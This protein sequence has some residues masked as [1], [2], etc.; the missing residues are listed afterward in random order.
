MKE[1]Y[2]G[3]DYGTSN[4]CVGIYM[5]GG[6]I[7]APNRIGE[8][9]TPSIVFIKDE[10]N[11]L[12]GEETIS[13]KLDD[14][15]NTI[16]EVKRFIGL[17]YE[18][19]TEMEY[20]KNLN[21]DIVNQNGI[22]K[23]KVNVNEKELF[24]S[25]EE[26][27]SLIIKKMVKCAE[28]FIAEKEGGI[29]ITKAIITVPAHFTEQ[30][31]EAVRSAAKMAGIEIP[32]I[33]NEP[34]AAAVAYGVGKDLV[35]QN[36]N[37][38]YKRITTLHT[39]VYKTD[40]SCEAPLPN[41][42]PKSNENI[43]VFDLGGGTLDITIMNLSKNN[44]GNINFEING[45][46]GDTHL[47]G[48]DFDNKLID[49]CIQEFC[50]QTGIKEE[51]IKKDKKSC[52]RLKIKCENAKKMLSITKET[53]I[54]V[55]NFYDKNDLFIR[56]T[57]DLFD[58]LCK[59]LYDRIEVLI[60][61]VFLDLGKELSEIDE[62]ILVGGATRMTGV[63]NLLGRLFG[64]HKVKDNL[65]PDEAVA[66][67]ATL[68]AAKMEEKDKVKFNLQDITAYK[69]GIASFN[70]DPNDKQNGDLM[71]PIIKKFSKIPSSK[72]K[73][74]KV[75]LNNN[76]PYI[77][78]KIYEG[79][80]KYVKKNKLLGEMRVDGINKL[81]L[82][83]YK[84]KFSV[85]VNGQLTV[86]ITID[87]LGIK[88]EEIIKEITHAVVDENKK[89]IKIIKN[90]N[91]STLHSVIGSINVI[92]QKLSE[93]YDISNKLDNLND[94]CFKYEELVKNYMLFVKENESIYEKVYLSTKELFSYYIERLKLKGKGENKIENII[95]NI[96]NLMNNLISQVGYLEDLIDMFTEIQKENNLKNE[97]YEI[98]INFIEILNSEG[99]KRKDNKEFSRY[100]SKLY[101][102]RAFF[103]AK[104]YIKENDLINID[105]SLF[106]RY[107]K[108]KKSSEGELKKVN[109][110]TD[111]IERRVKEG[112][113]IFGKTGFTMVGAK[114]DKF[115]RDMDSLKIEEIKDILDL[116]QNMA[117][118][119]DKK[120]NSIGE[121]YCIS[122]IIF[123]NYQFFNR[124][125]DKLWEYINRLK[126]I[127]FSHEGETYDWLNDAKYI[128]REVERQNSSTNQ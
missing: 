9:T 75:E 43:I 87:S 34:T 19:F 101:F 112:K 97:Y 71:Y 24:Y 52:K 20:D 61:N 26:I 30:Q 114:I 121:A 109:S 125:Y 59:D 22:P 94:C 36:E 35:V 90:K 115:E 74:F 91:L 3:I 83:E 69:L 57:R 17:N 6:V 65:N 11:V 116:F 119:F 78:I 47:G 10:K 27:S 46:D 29:K 82:I 55:D 28:D 110:F 49:Y 85:D 33:I 12:V 1:Y 41:E 100:Y 63:K 67:G 103:L 118:S 31:K 127:L 105:K 111:F 5:N 23:I 120:E 89:K 66:F 113:F 108:E 62:I 98:I 54:N 7:I 102:E 96:K 48:S 86:T 79:N 117:D 93:S 4:S 128:I 104:K 126:T 21:Y 13:Q 84:V 64:Q 73:N 50:K 81:G 122:N 80:E 58:D 40:D 107:E 124:G 72:E 70:P 92:K 88:K 106:E 18:D 123:I 37:S 95:Q 76:Y 2:I 32:R 68:E 16:Y 99:L 25:A 15:K 53:I 44:E 38:N 51:D 42:K 77:S 56:M 60:K 45:T 39:S 14:Y 8:R